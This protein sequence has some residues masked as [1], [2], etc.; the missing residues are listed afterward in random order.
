M[1]VAI[2]CGRN[3]VHHPIPDPSLAPSH[4]AIV[5]SG[6]RAIEFRQVAPWRTGSQHPEDPVQHPAIVNARHA[7]RF[8]GEKRLDNESVEVSQVIS[9]HAE[10]ESDSVAI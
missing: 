5:A 4:E 6:A 8:V 1:E 3:G 2:M 10:P 7:T 9:A